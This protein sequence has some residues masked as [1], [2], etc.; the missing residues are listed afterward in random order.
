M[1]PAVQAELEEHGVITVA[2]HPE[3]RSILSRLRGAGVLANPLPGVYLPAEDHSH[4]GWLRAVTAWSAP[5]GVLHGRSAAALWLPT[6]AGPLAFLAHPSLRSRRGVV[7]SRR[8]VPRAFVGEKAGIRFA[9]PAYAAV[10]LASTDDGRAICECLRRKLALPESLELALQ[11][12]DG[13]DGQVIRRNVVSAC[14]TKPWSYAELRLHRILLAAGITGWVANQPVQ[15]G[16]SVVWPDVLFL[17]TRL[18]LEFDGRETHGN[19]EQ[20]LSDRERQNQLEAAGYRV[21]RFG[22]EHLDDPAYVER[23]VRL[24]LRSGRIHPELA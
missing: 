19:R 6:L 15:A 8:L 7:V 22:W 13:A 10:E 9:L 24:A 3:L 2:T 23:M 18:V 4:L 17:G 14:A 5:H 21:L 20:F 1:H 12:L 11:A 16:K